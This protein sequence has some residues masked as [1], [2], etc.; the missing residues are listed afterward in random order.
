MSKNSHGEIFRG[1]GGAGSP[2]VDSR[3]GGGKFCFAGRPHPID[4]LCKIRNK[5]I[6]QILKS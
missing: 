2:S 6:G 1:G 4:Y 3:G 5:V